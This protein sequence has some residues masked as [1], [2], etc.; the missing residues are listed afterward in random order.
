MNAVLAAGRN[1]DSPR[2]IVRIAVY[3]YCG[4]RAALSDRVAA[5]SHRKF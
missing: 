5:T 3:Q 4:R 1:N 2:P